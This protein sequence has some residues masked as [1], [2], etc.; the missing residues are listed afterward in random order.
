MNADDELDS[1]LAGEDTF[2]TGDGQVSCS[3]M[4]SDEVMGAG[5][6]NAGVVLGK[7]SVLVRASAFPNI[8]TATS[9]Q[10]NGVDY[11][12]EQVMRVMDGKPIQVWLGDAL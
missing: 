10:V 5:P 4:E 2:L 11:R 8:A 12:V 6:G 7:G 1:I 3:F 9:A